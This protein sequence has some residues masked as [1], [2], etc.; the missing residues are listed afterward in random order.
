MAMET[1]EKAMLVDIIESL[2][3]MS[4]IVGATLAVLKDD[5]PNLKGRM[6]AALGTARISSLAGDDDTKSI[7]ARATAFVNTF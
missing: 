5:V 6:R 7:L 3:A 4:L 2:R 1:E